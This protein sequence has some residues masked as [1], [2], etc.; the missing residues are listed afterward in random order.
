VVLRTS[1]PAEYLT[2]W[3]TG[4]QV[5]VASA[6]ICTAHPAAK[7]LINPKTRRRLNALN[8]TQTKE[9]DG[10]DRARLETTEGEQGR[11]DPQE[12]G[13]GLQQG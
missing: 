1:A 10:R 3:G 5:E 12:S 8:I 9:N 2:K 6:P 7:S 13:E 11:E 4:W